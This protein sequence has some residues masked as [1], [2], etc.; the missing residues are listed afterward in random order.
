MGKIAKFVGLDVHRDT[1]ALAL[2]EGGP[3]LDVRYLGEMS[4]E[5]PK[6]VQRILESGEPGSVH[7]S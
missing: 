7:G 6:L 5:V 3:G 4:H 2:A 1:I